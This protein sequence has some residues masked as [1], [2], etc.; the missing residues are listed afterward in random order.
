MTEPVRLSKRLAEMLGCSRRDAERYIE[1]GWVRVNGEVVEEPQ[2]RVLDHKL[3]LMPGA[4]PNEVPPVTV[5]LHKPAGVV[6]HEDAAALL[7]LLTLASHAG[8][9]R[10]GVRVLKKHFFRQTL[11]APL[12]TAASGLAVLSQDWRVVRKLNEDAALIE[13]ELV[14]EV[15][16]NLP[17]EGMQQMGRS[18]PALKV[19]WQSENRLRFA[20]KG[21]QPGQIARLCE[22]AGL[23]V[24]GIKRIRIGRVPM[25]GLAPGQ[26]RYL[27]AHLRF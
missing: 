25:A 19:S 11:C 15:S 8:D 7:P 24:L 10:S 16:G 9:D 14:V 6:A 17:P 23:Q 22:Q 18:L 4:Q 2:H 12:E 1:G 3:E 26:W 20:V 13:Q 5:L 27:P 21:P